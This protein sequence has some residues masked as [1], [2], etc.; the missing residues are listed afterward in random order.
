M[1]SSMSR[2]FFE[3]LIDNLQPFNKFREHNFD[4]GYR[5][6]PL[7]SG[8]WN[9]AD[10]R[11]MIIVESLD[12]FDIRA[13]SLLNQH[14]PEHNAGS[15]MTTVFKNLLRLAY[16]G[17]QNHVE[18]FPK[19]APD[20]DVSKGF[21]F[22][23]SV[24]NF[25]AQKTFHLSETERNKAHTYFQTRVLRAVKILQPTHIL[26]CGPNAANAMLPDVNDLPFKNGWVFERQYGKVQ[27]QR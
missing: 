23:L 26:V 21:P 7:V 17:L 15:P 13:Q 6:V 12:S 4:D 3:G 24:V 9:D 2:R 18:A 1:E 5:I 11:L 14:D 16:K 20:Y 19:D 25:N 8:T 10:L 22:A 27:C